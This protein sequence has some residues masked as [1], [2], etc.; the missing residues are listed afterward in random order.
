MEH[1]D[2]LTNAAAA[3]VLKSSSDAAVRAL[4]RRGQSEHKN[5]PD[6]SGCRHC[7][8]FSMEHVDSL[9]NAAA[10]DVLKSSSDT[11]VRA[12]PRRGQS[13][14][15]NMPDLSGCRHCVFFSM[16]HWDSLTNAA[17]ADVLESSS[18]EAE[19]VLPRRGQSEHKNMPD[20]S[21]CRHCVFF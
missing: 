3:D 13:E 10:A 19:R 8:F 1:V 6:L 9:I 12:L 2:S 15:K 20:L 14:H 21:G 17:A 18:N 5:M 7:V 11:A 4:P 16:E